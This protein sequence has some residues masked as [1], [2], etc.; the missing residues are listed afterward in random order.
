[1]FAEPAGFSDIPIAVGQR[2]D[3]R[4]IGIGLKMGDFTP[5]W[6]LLTNFFPIFFIL[7]NFK[8][9][10]CRDLLQLLGSLLSGAFCVIVIA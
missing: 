5:M 4:N 9:L 1:V 8:R 7:R 2:R 6:K 10:L 3:N